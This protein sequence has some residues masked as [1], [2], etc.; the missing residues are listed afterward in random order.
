MGTEK[1]HRTS[2]EWWSA[3]FWGRLLSLLQ[4]T[5]Q[6]RKHVGNI[7]KK[8]TSTIKCDMTLAYQ[9][10]ISY[11]LAESK[12]NQ[13]GIRGEAKTQ[14]KSQSS[15]RKKRKEPMEEQNIDKQQK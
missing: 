5:P 6:D 13:R 1:L 9:G 4:E 11:T 8:P 3:Q 10:G 2:A 14:T 7:R 15:P 12:E